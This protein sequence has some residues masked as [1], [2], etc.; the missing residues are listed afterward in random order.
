MG[1]YFEES[2]NSYY[3]KKFLLC[4]LIQDD[5]KDRRQI[6][7]EQFYMIFMHLKKNILYQIFHT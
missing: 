2:S 7:T 6:K 1:T 4:N 5:I 3:N